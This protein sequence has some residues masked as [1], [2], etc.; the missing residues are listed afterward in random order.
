MITYKLRTHADIVKSS[1]QLQARIQNNHVQAED[2]CRCHQ[3]V[4][5]TAGQPASRTITYILR[6]STYIIK[7]SAQLQAN[8]HIHAEDKYTCHQMVSLTS[9]QHSE[10][11][12]TC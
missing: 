9:G 10:Q 3:I 7:S 4:S 6:M 2:K 5:L 11:S 12:R 8:N 1:A